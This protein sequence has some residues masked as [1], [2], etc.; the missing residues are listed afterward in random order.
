MKLY[1]L[2]SVHVY[3]FSCLNKLQ[4]NM[5]QYVSYFFD[6]QFSRVSNLKILELILS[7]IIWNFFYKSEFFSSSFLRG[8]FFH[9]R[10]KVRCLLIVSVL[11]S[12]VDIGGIQACCTSGFPQYLFLLNIW[13]L[14]ILIS[15]VWCTDFVS[16]AS[17]GEKGE[18]SLPQFAP[19]IV[20]NYT[21][22]KAFDIY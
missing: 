6:T 9:G 22:L 17:R 16:G 10:N 14:L 7:W 1:N 11:R 12:Q 20:N 4:N 21:S 19:K 18:F 8:Y 15:G 13:Y 3:T 2:L 5:V